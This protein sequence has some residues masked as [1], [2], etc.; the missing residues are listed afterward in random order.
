MP[1]PA[2]KMFMYLHAIEAAAG[3]SVTDMDAAVV[4]SGSIT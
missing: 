3:R 1:V 4:R 2:T